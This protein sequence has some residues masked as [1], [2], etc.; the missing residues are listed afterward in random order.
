MTTKPYNCDIK[1]Q[2]NSGSYDRQGFFGTKFRGGLN[3]LLTVGSFFNKIEY[4]EADWLVPLL[5]V[6]SVSNL[7]LYDYI[8]INPCIFVLIF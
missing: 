6:E 5:R 3:F 8:I 7:Q 1:C 4:S 2:S